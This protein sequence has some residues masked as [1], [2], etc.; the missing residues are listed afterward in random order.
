M[1]WLI[2]NNPLKIKREVIKLHEEDDP[3]IIAM[4]FPNCEIE[5]VAVSDGEYNE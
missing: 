4:N 2:L 5:D 1:K 3:E